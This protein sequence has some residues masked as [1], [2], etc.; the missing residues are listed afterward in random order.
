[1]AGFL[2]R[3]V[4]RLR[5][6]WHMEYRSSM[7]RGAVGNVLR[8]TLALLGG[9]A[10]VPAVYA[11]AEFSK[12]SAT[13][14]RGI[15]AEPELFAAIRRSDVATVK[16]VLRSHPEAIVERD[17]LGI[18]PL[19]YAEG[20]GEV[21]IVQVLLDRGARV[22]HVDSRGRTPLW[23]AAFYERPAMIRLLASRGG[24]VEA[25]DDQGVSPLQVATETGGDDAVRALRDAGAGE[26]S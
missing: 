10:V 26:R 20:M 16:S 11:A 9:A 2:Q 3:L 8:T 12:V 7:L 4:I 18:T 23:W 15:G 24:D 19:V 14:K 22:N 1:M 17:P 5:N 13:E 21:E 25:A 6:T